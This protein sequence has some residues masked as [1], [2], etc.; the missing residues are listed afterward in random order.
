M[1]KKIRETD[2]IWYFDATGGIHKKVNGQKQL[3]M[4]SIVCHDKKNKSLVPMV[5]FFTTS[6]DQ[7]TIISYLTFVERYFSDNIKTGLT[8][9]PIIV[10]DQSAA[11]MNALLKVFN[12]CSRLSY[13]N[14]TFENLINNKK[15]QSI[16]KIMKV[17]LINCAFHLIKIVIKSVKKK[18]KANER[19]NKFFVFCFTILQTSLYVDD[20]LNNLKHIYVLF[21]SK[22]QTSETQNSFDFLKKKL[23]FRKVDRKIMGF[24][25][26]QNQLKF[27]KQ[28]FTLNKMKIKL[29]KAQ[30]IQFISK[31][32]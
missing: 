19:I 18:S 26:H 14:W 16:K 31:H 21:N 29:K 10:T 4:Y 24:L 9:A 5:D 22:F 6:E 3:L 25:I 27:I 1:W 20:F 23:S 7:T 30:N 17:H 15:M 12:G 28:M 8:L 13:I 11:L 32:F 2:P